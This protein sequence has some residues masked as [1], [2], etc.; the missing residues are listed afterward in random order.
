MP[1]SPM[2]LDGET[3]WRLVHRSSL[4]SGNFFV[5]RNRDAPPS[6]CHRLLPI[7]EPLGDHP[8]RCVRNRTGWGEPDHRRGVLPLS[9]VPYSVFDESHPLAASQFTARPD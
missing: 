7:Q 1:T 6:V 3:V 9:A 4:E 5:I 2:L 8:Y